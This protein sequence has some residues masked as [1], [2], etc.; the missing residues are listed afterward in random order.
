MQ[1]SVATS[2]GNPPQFKTGQVCLVNL[3]EQNASV[4]SKKETAQ[5]VCE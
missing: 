1:I 2:R 4:F 5:G 3:Q